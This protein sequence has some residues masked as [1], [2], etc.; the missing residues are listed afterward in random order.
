MVSQSRIAVLSLKKTP[1]KDYPICEL[2]PI[3][4]IQQYHK[5]YLIKAMLQLH[6]VIVA[7]LF[8]KKY[9]DVVKMAL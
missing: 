8:Y 7:Q 5:K 3:P 9:H 2:S 4:R 1:F 6:A